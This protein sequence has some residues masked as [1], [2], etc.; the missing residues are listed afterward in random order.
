MRR[1]RFKLAAFA[2]ALLMSSCVSAC[3]TSDD[4]RRQ[5][6]ST[7]EPAA[8]FAP[9]V[10]LHP[11]ETWFPM[12]ARHFL[13]KSGLE[14]GG[15]PCRFERDISASASSN[16]AAGTPIPPLAPERLGRPPGYETWAAPASC[17]GRRPGLYSTAMRTRPF[18]REDRPVGLYVDEGFTLDIL[19]DA[20]P[21]RLR[22][23]G[24]GSLVGVPAYY[25]R[26]RVTVAGQPGVRLSYW[27]LY[28]HG[29][30]RDPDAK[31][32]VVDHEGDWERLDVLLQHRDG[33]S[34]Y[35]PI[36]V[37]YHSDTSVTTVNWDEVE[38]ARGTHPIADASRES[39]T[40][41][42]PDDCPDCTDW[43]TWRD[44]RDV[45]EQPWFGYGGGWGSIGATEASTGPLGP[46]PFELG[47]A[48]TI[49]S[50]QTDL[51]T[52]F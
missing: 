11:R 48:A 1:I 21:G 52:D 45:R 40:L 18:D 12:S 5:A 16:A 17:V 4:D 19:T 7:S 44:L 39:H 46:S 51:W 10:R 34:R 42:P 6:F 20:Q 36:A 23:D 29:Q 24:D 9:L 13:A 25:A 14:W 35:V 8:T 50:K 2:G 33:N 22:T 27:L 30:R 49:G 28:G 15:G 41:R 37:R 3:G 31:G 43:P 47:S 26:D 32:A 38:R